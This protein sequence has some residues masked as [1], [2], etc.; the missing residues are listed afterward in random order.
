MA[1]I[2]SKLHGGP[3]NGFTII[4]PTFGTS[5]VADSANDTLTLT[6]SDGTVTITGNATTDTINFSV[7][8]SSA[9]T[10]QHAYDNDPS[11]VPQIAF[12]PT[13]DFQIIGDY[14]SGSDGANM[15]LSASGAKTTGGSF[16]A[17]GGSVDGGGTA[18]SAQLVGGDANGKNCTSGFAYVSSGAANELSGCTSGYLL[19]Q[20]GGGWVASGDAYLKTGTALVDP[21]GISG[22]IEINTGDAAGASSGFIL[23]E[24]GVAVN[25]S[26]SISFVTGQ[27]N[28]TGNIELSTGAA[29]DD[30]SGSIVFRIGDSP[31]DAGSFQFIGSSTPS[32]FCAFIIQDCDY[33]YTGGDH[34]NWVLNTTNGTKWAT[35][36]TQKQA[37]WGATPVVQITGST[38]VLAGLVTVGLRA[39]SS[40]PP[41][42]LG[43]GTLTAGAINGTG[44]TLSTATPTITLTDS[45]GDDWTIKV[46]SGTFKVTNTTD[47]IDFFQMN[48]SEEAAFSTNYGPQSLI[49][50]Y[51]QKRSTSTS[52]GAAAAFTATQ[53]VV[54]GGAWAGGNQ[55]GF[56]GGVAY[57]ADQ[58][59]NNG[60]GLIG[61]EG[62]TTVISNTHTIQSAV[63][64]FG[65][66]SGSG[67]S[68][69]TIAACISNF[70]N[71]ASGHTVTSYYACK[72]TAAQ[73]SGT[74]TNQYG[75]FIPAMTS[76]TSNFEQ[77]MDTTAAIYFR[78]SG[79]KIYSSAASTV[80]IDASSTVN[81]RNA[82]TVQASFSSS[83]LT[84]AEGT[85]V[86]CG[87][88]TGTKFGTGST[89]KLGWW[90]TTAVVRSSG[91]GSITN[92]TTDKVYDANSTSLD[93]I[94]DVLGT[95]IA[96]L[97]SYGILGA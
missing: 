79:Q 68:T 21:D 44:L 85:N 27:A 41:L 43:T 57:I 65:T 45:G 18:G 87:T 97:V 6:S 92:V 26:G 88:A 61:L 22:N 78:A 69:T 82:G 34:L 50:L 91:W 53:E 71:V 95:L 63:G 52:S 2:E 23:L 11:A 31:G 38:D 56:L 24:S 49:G 72:L 46:A 60:A 96:Q 8:G 89:E 9:I 70:G 36:T 76:G 94:A 35:A 5:P 10:L 51:V 47:A 4:Q 73:N 59:F 37:W 40:N 28:S 84:M 80:D 93:E 81:F 17:N 86:K 16:I 32:N 29:Q 12:G 30:T 67:S 7:L 39:A 54:T 48:G 33:F 15:I 58:D 83:S 64:L 66:Y 62:G 90:G 77:W 19:L 20:T 55:R 13:I 25:G 42:N 75:L 74:I 14:A 3:I 1:R